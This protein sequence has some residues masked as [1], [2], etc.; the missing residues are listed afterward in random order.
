V[1]VLEKMYVPCVFP[2]TWEPAVPLEGKAR[3][4]IASQYFQRIHIDNPS[5]FGAH[6]F[7]VPGA[8]DCR[9]HLIAFTVAGIEAGAFGSVSADA[10]PRV[11]V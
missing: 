2:V 6:V 1:I 3:A 10:D 8:I 7:S 4:F 5:A 11:S 9:L